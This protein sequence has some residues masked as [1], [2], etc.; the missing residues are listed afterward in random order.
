MGNMD[1]L[2]VTCFSILC[3]YAGFVLIIEYAVRTPLPQCTVV[4][5]PLV[6]CYCDL[7]IIRDPRLGILDSHGDQKP[8]PDVDIGVASR[9]LVTTPD[10]AEGVFVFHLT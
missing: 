7:M 1:I 2:I 9:C 6:Q 4:C 5:S 3:Y 10:S 8:V